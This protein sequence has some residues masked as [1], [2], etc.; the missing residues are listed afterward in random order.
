[1]CCGPISSHNRASGEDDADADACAG[2]GQYLPA[3]P[4]LLVYLLTFTLLRTQHQLNMA[5]STL[6]KSAGHRSAV[7]QVCPCCQRNLHPSTIARHQRGE[8][9]VVYRASQVERERDEGWS[10]LADARPVKRSRYRREE[11]GASQQEEQDGG[12]N[13]GG[14]SWQPPEG[15]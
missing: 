3:L 2:D 5:P 14:P 8:V 9:P 4:Q 13:E 10:I 7:R 15:E 12:V 6:Q 11:G 1:M